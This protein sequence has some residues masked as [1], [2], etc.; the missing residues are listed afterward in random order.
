[1]EAGKPDGWFDLG[2]EEGKE[3]K[4]YVL[5][6]SADGFEPWGTYPTYD[7]WSNP[8]TGQVFWEGTIK[9]ALPKFHAQIL[10]ITGAETTPDHKPNSIG[11]KKGT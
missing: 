2:E 10:G 6:V 8:N 11:N 3:K 5:E 9:V 7:N 1:M 4:K